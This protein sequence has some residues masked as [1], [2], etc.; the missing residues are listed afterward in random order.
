MKNKSKKWL[1]A[2]LALSMTFAC[3]TAVSC[4]ESQTTPGGQP[5]VIEPSSDGSEIGTY[6]CDA[7][8]EEYTVT[9][10]N[11]FKVFF[12]VQGKLEV[13]SYVIEEGNLTFTF[14][15]EEGAQNVEMTATLTNGVMSFTYNGAAMTFLKKVN[16]TVSFEMNGGN[17]VD[18]Q[19][20]LNGKTGEQPKAPTYAGHVL[21]G[22]YKDA[23][24]TA[25]FDFAAPITKD[26]TVYAYWAE[27]PEGTAEYK[28]NYNYNY[29][30]A[31][32]ASAETIG[33]KLYNV[34]QPQREGFTFGGWW[35][36]MYND[37]EKLSFEWT[38]DYT[39]AE[40]TTLYAVWIPET[41]EM[42][43]PVI[44]IGE[45]K[46]SWNDVYGATMYKVTVVDP[47]G[48][49]VVDG[50]TTL[51]T[52]IAFDFAAA[53]AG[54][55][56][57]SVV[58]KGAT[59]E[60]KEGK[61]YYRNK[62]L[63]RV[64]QFDVV[65]SVLIFN[66][67]ENA[68]KYL[69]TV[70]CGNGD[71]EHILVDNDKNTTYNFSTCDM[72][73]DGIKFTV[74]AVADG[75][76]SSESAQ[77]VYNRILNAV[78][79]I[80][81]NDE[82]Q[83]VSWN[84]VDYATN[85]IVE[86]V[87]ADGKKYEVDN[88]TSTK[89]SLKDFEAGELQISV[90]PKTKGYN[91][92][93]AT[94][95]THNKTGLAAPSGMSITD[96]VLSWNP[97]QGA[98]GGYVVE[99]AGKTLKTNE[100][101]IELDAEDLGLDA[102]DS[103][104]IR[105]MAK[106]DGANTSLW[107]DSFKVT[108][109]QMGSVSYEKNTVKWNSVFGADGYEVQVNGG[110]IQ[111][112][113]PSKTSAGIA[114]TKA[115]NNTVA[116]RFTDGD[117]K[118]DWT[119]IEVFAYTMTFDTR[120]GE[121]IA[122]QYVALGDEYTLPTAEKAGYKFLNWYSAP[123]GP[124]G[125]AMKYENGVLE[126][127]SDFVL[128]AYYQAKTYNI[129]YAYEGG[130]GEAVSGNATFNEYFTLDIA[131]PTDGRMMFAGWWTAP[132]GRG[133]QVTDENGQSLEKWTTAEENVTLYAHWYEV[134]S[135]D[136]LSDG[137]Y[138]V[139]K[140][141]EISMLSK[142]RIPAY[143]QGTKVTVVEGYAFR[144]VKTLEVVEIPDSIQL[145]ETGTAFYSCTNLKEIYV[146]EVEGN[147]T[148]YYSSEDGALIF[149]DEVTSDTQI[150][151]F[152]AAKT[153]EYVIPSG[154]TYLQPRLFAN[155]LLTKITI[156]K[157]VVEIGTNAFYNCKN[158]TEI[159]FEGDDPA[160]A[161]VTMAANAINSCKKLTTVRL[162]AHVQE[163][164]RA[165]I[166][167]CENLAYI[168]VSEANPVL[169]SIDGMLAAQL[170]DLGTTIVYCPQGRTGDMVI[171]GTV[172]AIGDYAFTNC[173]NITSLTVHG[174]VSYIG[175]QAFYNADNIAFVVF[176][177]NAL[178]DMTIGASAFQSINE[179]ASVTFESGSRV[180]SL[181]KQ[182]FSY[183][184]K[185]TVFN[186]PA[187]LQSIGDSA[188]SYCSG[189]E[190]VIFPKDGAEL[191][192]GKT[193]FSNCTS[194][195]EVYIS[196]SVVEMSFN[197]FNGCS[198]LEGVYVADENEYFKDIDGVLYDENETTILFYP[199]GRTDAEYTAMPATVTKIGSMAFAG[200][201][202]LETVKIAPHITFIGE[203][204][205]KDCTSLKTLTFTPAAEGA[206]EVALTIGAS[207]FENCTGLT[208]VA[209]PDRLTVIAEK[210]FYMSKNITSLTLGGKVTEIGTRA[211]AGKDG[212]NMMSFETIT[213]PGSVKEIGSYAFSY[214]GA[215]TITV[216]DGVGKI[217]DHAFYYCNK[218]TTVSF[219]EGVSEV[220]NW[221]FAYCSA[222][223]QVSLP[224]TVEK[225][226]FRAF[227]SCTAMTSISI[228]DP[229]EV[230]TAEDTEN[231]EKT[232]NTENPETAAV[233]LYLG[234][235][236]TK[237]VPE[238][239]T[240]YIFY[241]CSKLATVN[242]PKRTAIIGDKAFYSITSIK[243]VTIPE[244]NALQWI[245]P[246][247]FYGCT[248]MAGTFYIPKTVTNYTFEGKE[249]A[250]IGKQAFQNCKA[251]TNVIFEEGGTAPLSIGAQAFA[252]AKL[253]SITL[254]ARLTATATLEAVPSN[255][256]S[257]CTSL[258]SINVEDMA[259]FEEA[260]KSH[261]GVLYA[262]G[263]TT[264]YL[265]P[266]GKTGALEIPAFV[267]K[268][269]AGSFM[270]CASL[271]ALT[272]AE[273]AEG[274]E[275]LPLII[276]DGTSS[277]GA[278]YKCKLSSVKFPARLT[279]IGAYAFAGS[280][281]TVCPTWTS[282]EIPATV[283]EI[284]EGAFYY[285]A[286][287]T[288]FT[289]KKNEEGKIGVTSLPTKMFY[290]C[291]QLKTIEIPTEI[292][293]I[294]DY[295]FYGC[296]V[297]PNVTLPATI[298]EI[299]GYAFYGCK[300]FTAFTVP[301][302]VQ[303]IGNNAFYNCNKLTTVTFA[304]DEEGKTQITEM[305]NSVFYGCSVLANIEIPASMVTM[306]NE[307][308]ENCTALKKLN[309]A[310]NSVLT[311]VGKNFFEKAGV[312]EVS[313]PNSVT[314]F[315]E[316]KTFYNATNLVTVTLPDSLELPDDF[317]PNNL[318]YS[319]AKLTTINVNADSLNYSS[320]DGVLFNKDGSILLCYPIAKT[321]AATETAA[322]NEYT[323][324]DT[325]E[326]IGTYAFYKT[327]VKIVH[328]PASVEV[329]GERAFNSN[330]AL[331][332]VDIATENASL[333]EIG[334][335]AFQS[336]SK[337]ASIN[338]PDSLQIIEKNSLQD[339]V[340]TALEIPASVESIG[341]YALEGA[342]KLT[343]VTFQEGSQLTSLGTHVFD[344][345]ALL[346]TIEI[347]N[348]VTAIG[349][350]AFLNCKKLTTVTIGEES[351]L[352]KIDKSAFKGCVLLTGIFV[353]NGVTEIGVTAFDGCTK[354]ASVTFQEG[355]TAD[356]TIGPTTSAST[357]TKTFNG[358]TSLKEI[359]LPKRIVKLGGYA[360]DGC[361]NL[362]TVE[363]PQ[364]ARLQTF[365]ANTFKGMAK[366]KAVHI[367]A[368]VSEIPANAFDGCT[369]LE[370]VTI[371]NGPTKIGNY[372]FQGCKFTAIEI[373]KSVVSIGNSA[374]KNCTLLKDLV[375]DVGLEEIG[376]YAFENC[377]ELEEFLITGALLTLGSNPFRGCTKL[378]NVE[379]SSDN[380]AF[381][382][383]DG[384]LYNNEQ[385]MMIYYPPCKTGAFTIPET[386][387]A[388]ADGVFASTQLTE[389]T[390]PAGVTEITDLCFE[391]CTALQKVVLHGNITKI[392]ASAFKGCY[393][394]DDIDFT[395]ATGLTEIGASAFEGCTG[396]STA[397]FSKS[398]S[399]AKIGNNAFKDCAILETVKFS[400]A[401]KSVGDYAFHGT[402][403]TEIA[404]GNGLETV[405]AYAFENVTGI[406]AYALPA[407]LITIGDY[408]FHGVP[409]TS[410]TFGENVT[411]IGA[412]AFQGLQAT[413]LTLPESVETI[414][415]YA[416][417]GW[418]NLAALSIP[419]NVTK[420]GE[421]A[422]QGATSLQTLTFAKGGK[423]ALVIGDYAFEGC[424][425]LTAV[426]I[427]HRA[428]STSRATS[429]TS[430]ATYVG[431]P[432][433]G[434][435]AFANCSLLSTL[436][437]EAE[438]EKYQENITQYG[439]YLRSTTIGDYAFY[440][441][442]VTAVNLP[443]YV[444]NYYYTANSQAGESSS[445]AL[446][447]IGNY[448]FAE[449][450]ALAELNFAEKYAA[451][452]TY[453]SASISVSIGK[454]A[455]Y[456]CAALEGFEIPTS[457]SST[458]TVTTPVSMV[459]NYAFAESGLKTVNIPDVLSFTA[460]YGAF[461]N[462]KQ[463]TSVTIGGGTFYGP[464]TAA[465]DSEL[466]AFEGCTAL[467]DVTLPADA[468]NIAAAMFRG[469]TALK[470]ITLPSEKLSTI[471][472][473]AFE[474]CAAI[475]ELAIPAC[476]TTIK[477]GAFKGCTGIT[478]M[479]IGDNVTTMG[480]N[481]FEGWTAAQTISFGIQAA[482]ASWNEAWYA[483]SAATCVWLPAAEEAA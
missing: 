333:K 246:Q 259:D 481:V 159:Y 101:N 347:P 476:V 270:N 115:G 130:E 223:T 328:I 238:F 325:V 133:V 9:L 40:P 298:T 428:R 195:Q 407:S 92:P 212:N 152:P 65:D 1:L 339:T 350:S 289:F 23:E 43:A 136:L 157:S 87:T 394:L 201:T 362:A 403:I 232:E 427:P 424:T 4:G 451:L 66:E 265:C 236:T 220:G 425:A 440:K 437:F 281:A 266:E 29:D 44:R 161:P 96:M 213:V 114:L 116:V 71:H 61:I 417:Q 462:C 479:A 432:S 400:D 211:F 252:A 144:S 154:V 162:P 354:L 3:G 387:E 410:V 341:N 230:A 416:F 353:P 78:T 405:G 151:F 464:N 330:T 84:A 429:N 326:Q 356:L 421:Y 300:A 209:L 134:F 472:Q 138:A 388:F 202:H 482:Y 181:G 13:G 89:L 30:G 147:H 436:T 226:G 85:Y 160:S 345:C 46:L 82:T 57:I 165:C 413:A 112:F 53:K 287:M 129:L 290:N 383:E 447:A 176:E 365:Y 401:V 288:T 243:T 91:S 80:T 68:E 332:T 409:F 357:Q 398:A 95:I 254:P 381:Y 267:T 378:A 317:N 399:L 217:S 404:Y 376:D 477:D 6:Y 340:L 72:Q 369:S 419:Q 415:D 423:Q 105:I 255:T 206:E 205:F 359:H 177:E 306:G 327:L 100:T 51:N 379:V 253:S 444:R 74:R 229:E 443:D 392:G 453:S 128:Y 343:S 127:A 19:S 234:I 286:K 123:S 172:T 271:T 83:E 319:A 119:E 430:Y 406:A 231:T 139:S 168:N 366:L 54:D 375:F 242:L 352:T 433:V 262:D 361:T 313:F 146:Y 42:K 12:S 150:A 351:K 442:A 344:G 156:P 337:L 269:A 55:Y 193:V 197:V 274:E 480:A 368:G 367:P 460:Y 450:T 257:G 86:I 302:S 382:A 75:Y 20:V 334:P 62:A 251:L 408:A 120:M 311:T 256:F 67:V 15:G 331:T 418:T 338:L 186:I 468:Y 173:K 64:S 27:K 445:T 69:I 370:T 473:Y 155:V 293:K 245:G 240:G 103:Y 18:S 216:Q 126:N 470:N 34:P 422:F 45:N 439:Y 199:M 26:T 268:I 310:P 99:I 143:Y 93:E 275:A 273:P 335:S 455:F 272:F 475:T 175:A 11:D 196:A 102:N 110:E 210:L 180:V 169:S 364:G 467:T 184:A 373:P 73:A 174:N 318:F 198:A 412:Y 371:E 463:L 227:Q 17:P 322:A 411:S 111:S 431:V 305:G 28:V 140:G 454:Y 10:L 303:S 59:G 261:D 203:A 441:T 420:I 142:V 182:A 395:Y 149:F 465:T 189:L 107:S 478:A 314:T 221:A 321:L 258:K 402:A 323:V 446:Y 192:F 241:S 285:N 183:C 315:V 16:Y 81:V 355:G 185:M 49:A 94:K 77:Y 248:A 39:F 295:A 8:G 324:P 148:K 38:K 98:T 207:A 141:S 360:F 278:F 336:C 292:T 448:A 377:A 14:A 329:I 108:Y 397:D 483:G 117:Y 137:T 164:D 466:G 307:V 170:P 264:T 35:V 153:G 31:E 260:F 200:N 276:E 104:E 214:N 250:G 121:P 456:K 187:S 316:N 228:A 208:E 97:V 47:N 474:G 469:C 282:V 33:G 459:N 191:T 2:T 247:A 37:G 449:C 158:L 222:L 79:G 390:I 372:A 179:L 52:E 457:L 296:T 225:I 299:G 279:K 24:F 244:G 237:E 263:G 426:E 235:D 22:W 56:E 224:A 204:A 58:A 178:V 194:L 5:P 297:L 32:N 21:L 348:G 294:S 118:S 374:F 7:D 461:S 171:P 113:G 41:E 384:V 386:V 190:E 63:A 249:M 342:A 188:F 88:K 471:N 219:G 414:G 218:A 135:F 60:N 284:G 452:S 291:S 385:T 36:S 301:A 435:Y 320:Q 90:Y 458:G 167:A 304:K 145:V 25:P 438:P 391:N 163:L 308:F 283:T 346:A 396:I 48:E 312:T 215:T 70:E 363:I 393:M 389:I 166:S 76:A 125:N 358:C 122:E 280:S 131:T 233:P 349:D 132:G 309:F 380:L 50:Q 106:G 124:A 109:Y 239:D 434:N 277:M